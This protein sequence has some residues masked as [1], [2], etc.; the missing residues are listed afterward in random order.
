MERC[1]PHRASWKSRFIL[2]FQCDLL[3]QHWIDRSLPRKVRKLFQHAP[4][5]YFGAIMDAFYFSILAC[6]HCWNIFMINRYCF[7]SKEQVQHRF[8]FKKLGVN[9]NNKRPC[10]LCVQGRWDGGALSSVVGCRCQGW[11]TMTQRRWKR[12]LRNKF[13]QESSCGWL[14]RST[15]ELTADSTKR[16]RGSKGMG[17]VGWAGV[18]QFK[19]NSFDVSQEAGTGKRGPAFSPGH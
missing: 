2:D 17:G 12:S 1:S 7:C 5:A 18:S 19:Q 16:E 13:Q 8:I 3:A 4:C 11:G 6:L 10:R 15:A 14:L 9:L